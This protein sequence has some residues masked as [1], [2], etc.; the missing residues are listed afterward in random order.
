VSTTANRTHVNSLERLHAI[1]VRLIT[2]ATPEAVAVAVCE[3]AASA[4]D[5][6]ADTLALS[7]PTAAGL[8]VVGAR[9]H[10]HARVEARPRMTVDDPSPLA[11]ALRRTEAVW[12]GSVAE[13]D[14]A[15]PALASLS[16]DSQAVCAMPLRLGG[17]AFG[18]LSFSF[19]VEHPFSPEDRSFLLAVA[20]HCAL[21][22]DRC[23]EPDPPQPDS[24][25]TTLVVEGRDTVSPLGV[26]RL[27]QQ[28]GEPMPAERLDDALLCA[29][30]LVTNALMHTAGPVRVRVSGDQHSI[31]IEVE[32]TSDQPPVLMGDPQAIGGRGLL[33][34]DA[35]TS[36]W[37][38]IRR[39]WGKTVWAE[40]GSPGAR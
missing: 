1:A 6:S 29:S 10:P 28:L 14:E 2:A 21:A 34:V 37:G 30:E 40:I 7:D 12:L 26:R 23:H 11:H 17:P 19:D 13:R 32:D 3:E 4:V 36:S 18:A 5:A 27:V 15:F 31:R 38:T 22:I 39:S 24:P 16:F 9:G 8:R 20:D 33:V 25:R 35:L